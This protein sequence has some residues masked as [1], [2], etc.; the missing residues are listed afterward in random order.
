MRIGEVARQ[1]GLSERSLRHYEELGLVQPVRSMAGQRVYQAPDLLRLQQ[2]LDLKRAGL[3]LA[4]IG[5]FLSGE[6]RPTATLLRAHRAFLEEK[7]AS[8]EQALIA[9]DR[10]LLAIQ[11]SA[12]PDL[13]DL[14][15]MIRSGEEMMNEEAKWQKVYDKYYIAEEQARWLK[16]KQAVGDTLIAQAEDAWP[17]LIARVEALVDGG[18]DPGSAEAQQALQEWNALLQ[19]IYDQDPGLLEGANRL[20]EN[21][22]D[23]PAD[24]PQPPFRQDVYDFMVKAAGSSSAS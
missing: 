7:K 22:D 17:K 1:T 18:A 16:A 2:I 19:P 11:R 14:C 10:A 21:M 4:Q 5:E 6:T 12:S 20:Y 15:T 8:L 23:W 3:S 24:G 9:T 13:A